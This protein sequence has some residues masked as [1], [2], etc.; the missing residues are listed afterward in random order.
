[1]KYAIAKVVNGNYSIHAEGFEDLTQAKVNYFGLC[2]A[3]WAA[4]NVITGCVA[5]IDENLGVYM[6]NTEAY[7]TII[8]HTPTPEPTPEPEPTPD[9]E[10]LV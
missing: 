1:M 10:V 7:R 8:T 4:D 3:L 6:D 2:Q 9:P 5:I